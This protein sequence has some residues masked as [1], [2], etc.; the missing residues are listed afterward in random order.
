MNTSEIAGILVTLE[1]SGEQSLYLML[2]DDGTVHRKGNLLGDLDDDLYIGV[3]QPDLFSGAV[4]LV[5]P[6][7]LARGGLYTQP[8]TSGPIYQLTVG[9]SLRGSKEVMIGF[10]YDS[11]SIQPPDDI[12]Q[13]VTRVAEL[14]KPWHDA[15]KSIAKTRKPTAG[16]R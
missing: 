5:N 14:T 10:R 3:A 8:T 9:F 16:G 6:D 15:Q 7:W 11:S 2:K 4:S 12:L 13:F 1:T